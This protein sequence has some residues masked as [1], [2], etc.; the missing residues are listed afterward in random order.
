MSNCWMVGP[1]KK[2]PLLGDEGTKGGCHHADLR[3]ASSTACV[4]AKREKEESTGWIYTAERET[5]QEGGRWREA[6]LEA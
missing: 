2:L 3:I 5:E 6:A 4:K 1:K